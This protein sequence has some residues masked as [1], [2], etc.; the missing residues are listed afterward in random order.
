[1]LQSDFYSDGTEFFAIGKYDEE[2]E[3][4]TVGEERIST[5]LGGHFKCVHGRHEP[6]LLYPTLCGV[7]LQYG[8]AVST[9]YLV[10]EP[11]F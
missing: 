3:T 10:R 9:C 6:S 4:F 1:M 8:T 2:S 5:D 11:S 7:T